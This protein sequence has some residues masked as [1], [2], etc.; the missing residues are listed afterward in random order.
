MSGVI[1]NF[2]KAIAE[3]KAV[4]EDDERLLALSGREMTATERKLRQTLWLNHGCNQGFG[5]LYGDDG[6]LQCHKCGGDFLRQSL[7]CLADNI[8]HPFPGNFFKE[9]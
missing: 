1:D 2:D 6:E 4:R 8:D 9:R 3:I 5:D 7:S